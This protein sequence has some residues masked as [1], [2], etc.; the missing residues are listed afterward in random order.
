MYCTG[1][2]V[3]RNLAEAVKWYRRSAEQGDRYAQYNLAVMLIKGQ[4]APQ[5][6]EE[7]FRWCCLAAE[8]GLAE[9]QRQL[10]ELFHAGHGVAANIALADATRAARAD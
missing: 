10:S 8:Q 4:G 3:V 7:A 9:A 1:T 2:G 5:D 6:S